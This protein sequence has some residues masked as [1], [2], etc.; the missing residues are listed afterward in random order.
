MTSSTFLWLSMSFCDMYASC[1]Y[2]SHRSGRT[3]EGER[4]VPSLIDL[5]FSVDAPTFHRSLQLPNRIEQK[6]LTARLPSQHNHLTCPPVT[7]LMPKA[8]PC[9]HLCPLIQIPDPAQR[10]PLPTYA[11]NHLL[12]QTLSFCVRVAFAY[13]AA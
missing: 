4:L 12:A 5:Q 8:L 1:G 7:N 11:D 9:T 2:R 13:C 6:R 10:L 3:V